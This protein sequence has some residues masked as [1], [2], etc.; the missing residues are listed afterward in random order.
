MVEKRAWYTLSAHALNRAGIPARLGTIVHVCNTCN[1]ILRH[2]LLV[3]WIS[4]QILQN[5]CRSSLLKVLLTT[6]VIP[7]RQGSGERREQHDNSYVSIVVAVRVYCSPYRLG[8]LL[9]AVQDV[10]LSKLALL[11]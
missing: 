6:L 1:A 4:L 3:L 2:R 11:F 5:E 10:W 7:Y 9:A 8:T